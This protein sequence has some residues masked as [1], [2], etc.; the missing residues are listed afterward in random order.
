MSD[1]NDEGTGIADLRKQYDQLVKDNATIAAELKTLR[2]EKRSQT[3]SD[4]LKAKGKDPGAARFYS[5]EDISDDKVSAWF[6]DVKG[7]LADFKEAEENGQDA[8]NGGQANGQAQVPDPNSEAARLIAA[9]SG[10]SVQIPAGMPNGP[11]G[12]PDQLS[13]LFNSIDPSSPEGFKKAQEL[14]FFPKGTFG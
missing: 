14:G 12:T 7:S 5:D 2:G 13:A 3:V 1:V 4:Y 6:E 11:T 9:N 10:G 8:T